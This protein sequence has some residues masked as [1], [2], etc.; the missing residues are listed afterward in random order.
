MDSEEKIII[1]DSEDIKNIFI[2][3]NI[4]KKTTMVFSAFSAWEN[5]AYIMEALSVTAQKC[6]DEGKSE[7][8][9]YSAIKNYLAS[10]LGTY[11]ILESKKVE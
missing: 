3:I 11:N 7:K 4:K 8:E 9:V 1:K 10:V 2:Q 6:I 5:L